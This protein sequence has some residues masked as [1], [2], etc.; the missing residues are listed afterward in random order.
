MTVHPKKENSIVHKQQMVIPENMHRSNIIQTHLVVLR[1]M[2]VTA[3]NEQKRLW[4]S[5]RARR[6]HGCSDI[7]K[8][9]SYRPHKVGQGSSGILICC[10]NPCWSRFLGDIVALSDLS[11]RT[12]PIIKFYYSNLNLGR[13]KSLV[14]CLIWGE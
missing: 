4:I 9:P 8:K 10:Y 2:H 14:Y 7:M 1:Y 11:W 5:K 13:V 6:V 3:F 12:K